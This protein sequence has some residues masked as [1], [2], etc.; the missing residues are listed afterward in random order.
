M[1]NGA[2]PS[3]VGTGKH[4][5]AED[6]LSSYGL[7]LTLFSKDHAAKPTLLTLASGSRAGS[8]KAQPS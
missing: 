5:G 1:V 8:S 4:S 7:A 2:R 3:L 6:V